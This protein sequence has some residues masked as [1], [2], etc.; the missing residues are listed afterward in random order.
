MGASYSIDDRV[1]PEEVSLHEGAAPRAIR[2][3]LLPEDQGQF[4]HAYEDALTDARTTGEFTTLF[5][6][7]E[8]WRGIAALQRDPDIFARVARRA[9]EKLIGESSPADE[10]VHVTRAKACM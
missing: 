6:T 1:A 9:A 5:R 10:P 3:T 4:D 2:T 8:H 7:L